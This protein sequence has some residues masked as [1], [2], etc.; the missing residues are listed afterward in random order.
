MSA[1]Q[2]CDMKCSLILPPPLLAGDQTL[3]VATFKMVFL[4][5]NTKV[6]YSAALGFCYEM[7]RCSFPILFDVPKPRR[8]NHLNICHA[9]QMEY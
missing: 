4:E 1:S 8:K 9:A 5:C 7:Q 6:I 2:F 3:P